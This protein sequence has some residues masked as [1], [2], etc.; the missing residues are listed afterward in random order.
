MK[1][2]IFGE[3]T[4]SYGSHPYEQGREFEQAL[5]SQWAAV[6]HFS[7]DSN[8]AAEVRL[9]AFAVRGMTI[10]EVYKRLKDAVA[11]ASEVTDWNIWTV[12]ELV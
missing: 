1:I 2:T 6:E 11:Y 3:H 5:K 9:D 10:E 7:F 8:S 4:A 12:Q